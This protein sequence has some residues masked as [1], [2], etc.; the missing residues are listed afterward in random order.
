MA[1]LMCLSLNEDETVDWRAGAL[2]QFLNF[3]PCSLAARVSHCL[4]VQNVFP[5][6]WLSVSLAGVAVVPDGRWLA[7]HTYY[8]PFS[9]ILHPACVGFVLHHTVSAQRLYLKLHAK[10]RIHRGSIYNVCYSAVAVLHCCY[11]RWSV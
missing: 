10:P 6:C 7:G 8:E 2:L 11:Q 4:P 3:P 1:V 5:L 9:Q